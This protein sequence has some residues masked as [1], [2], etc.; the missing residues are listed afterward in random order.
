MNPAHGVL[1]GRQKQESGPA[2][3][4]HP[5]ADNDGLAGTGR[6]REDHAKRVRSSWDGSLFRHTVAS[7]PLSHAARCTVSVELSGMLNDNVNSMRQL[8]VNSRRPIGSSGG[9]GRAGRRVYLTRLKVYPGLVK[10]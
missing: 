1:G 3:P 5:L 9:G 8:I 2:D 6:A 4:T 10:R 7:Y